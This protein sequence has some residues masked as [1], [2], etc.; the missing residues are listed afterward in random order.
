MFTPLARG[1]VV[2]VRLLLRRSLLFGHVAEVDAD[3]I[4]DAGGSAHAID[5]DIVDGE[6][7][8]GFR[9]CL[10]PALEPGFSCGFVR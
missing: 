5:E 8:C 7:G 3:A 9:M 4:P 10:P 6:Q 1:I 2:R